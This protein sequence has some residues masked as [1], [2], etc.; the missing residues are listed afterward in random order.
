V[1]LQRIFERLGRPELAPLVDELARRFEAGDTP[2]TVTLRDV[3]DPS[4]QALADLMG[5]DRRPPPTSRLTVRKILAVLDLDSVAELRLAVET[6][7]GPLTNRRAVR[8]EARAAR[9]A[10]WSWLGEEAGA[11]GL[12]GPGARLASWVEDQR[13]AGARGGVQIHRRRLESALEVLRRLPSDGTSLASLANDATGDP[14]ALDYG[15]TLSGMVLDAIGYAFEYPKAGDAEAAR[16]MW[17]MAGVVPDPHSSTVLALGVSGDD[18]TALGRWLVA[19][20]AVGEPVV[21]SLA[22]LRRWPVPA[23]PEAGCVYVIENPSIIAEASPEWNGPPLVCSSGRPTIATVT[24]LRQLAA[25]GAIVHQ[26]ADFDPTG[27]A[28]TAWL[29][30]RAACIPWKMT[31]ADYLASVSSAAPVFTGEPPET[32]WDPALQPVMSEHRRALYEEEIRHQ[33]LQS[34]LTCPSNS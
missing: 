20:A 3:A 9:L 10:L 33:L 1:P 14:H 23:A 18:R 12:G 29:A 25:A 4:R 34:I 6:L 11:V 17:E 8:S 15:R 7:R 21:L 5:A 26:H 13:A 32:P 16:S 2:V 27:L 28:I 30:E 24:L 31:R 22:Q 19:C